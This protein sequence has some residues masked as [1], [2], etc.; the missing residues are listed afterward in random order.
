MLTPIWREACIEYRL[1]AARPKAQLKGQASE[2]REG[3]RCALGKGLLNGSFQF[4][5]MFAWIPKRM[6]MGPQKNAIV[7][8]KA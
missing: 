1:F 4:Q 7:L 5:L 2:A 6:A 8:G 3:Q